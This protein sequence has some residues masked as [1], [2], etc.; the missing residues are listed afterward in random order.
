MGT[1]AV[2]LGTSGMS[3]PAASVDDA[4][5]LRQDA[6]RTA[7][8][9]ALLR[10]AD[11]DA[12]IRALTRML[13]EETDRQARRL[14]LLAIAESPAVPNAL[15]EP[16]IGLVGL[17]TEEE[18][19]AAL[20]ALGSTATQ[21]A[22][23]VLVNH[24]APFMPADVNEA[25]VNGL[26]RMTGRADLGSDAAT[27]R[28]WLESAELLDEAAWQ[29]E[30]IRGLRGRSDG[31]GRS[32]TASMLATTDIYKRHFR[33]VPF[34]DRDGLLAEMLRSGG[35]L[36]T[37]GIEL[38][39]R[40]IAGNREIGDVVGEAALEMLASPQT[41]TRIE[42]A[43]LVSTLRPPEAGTRLTRAL[44]I[45]TEAASAKAL[46]A[47]CARWPRVA[48]V[49]P[50][51]RWVEFGSE[52]RDEASSL[53][54]ALDAEGL[55]T[56]PADRRRVAGALRAAGPVK[57]MPDGLRLLVLTGTEDD[58][59]AVA[60]LMDEPDAESR[61]AAAAALARRPEFLGRIVA[62][63]ARDPVLYPAVVTAIATHRPTADGYATLRRIQ[64]SSKSAAR[65]GLL[66]VAR[67]LS[68]RD[69][70]TVAQT[71]ETDP[72]MRVAVLS[73]VGTAAA[74][75]A[76]RATINETKLLLAETQLELERPEP[77][78]ASLAQIVSNAPE[79]ARRADELRVT[80]LLWL[81]RIDEAQAIASSAEAWLVAI[82]HFADEPH[83]PQVAKATLER[84]GDV[85][86]DAER[87]RLSAVAAIA[88]SEGSETNDSGG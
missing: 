30:L 85:L 6:A 47:A 26:I 37:L 31:L 86:Q 74:S 55:L 88:A 61:G 83:A 69:V 72:D 29:R 38:L 19:T 70:L 44:E 68:A 12:E 71:I 1:L 24:A 65:T 58:R 14:L 54:F 53:L 2:S 49:Q 62:A 21:R 66:A 73:T 22:A 50:A 36:Q 76:E 82:D 78:L 27:W 57:L 4:D 11:T 75:P 10:E 3:Q 32:L 59:E 87:A 23:R 7:A 51:L 42:A 45:E 9:Q 16:L 80:S 34:Q 20:R 8:L 28:Q 17:G 33:V 46:L 77:A 81:N 5:P 18:R 25:A 56:S 13:T 79:V 39:Y 43:R 15:D 48:A 35:A 64:P 60:S 41:E 84:F 52:T 63:A 40:E 67:T